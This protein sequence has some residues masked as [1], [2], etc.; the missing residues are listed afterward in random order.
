MAD[1]TRIDKVA[2]SRAGI[3]QRLDLGQILNGVQAERLKELLRGAVKLRAT[4]RI[5]TPRDPHKPLLHQLP[6]DFSA[7][8]AANLLHFRTHDRLLIRDHRERFERRGGQLQFV[9]RAF[10]ACEPRVVARSREKLIPA[11][12]FLDLKRAAIGV[13]QL[14]ESIQ[15]R[16]SFGRVGEIG[17]LR[18]TASGQ[19]FVGKQQQCFETG[20]LG[21]TSV[22]IEQELRPF[23]GETGT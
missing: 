8:H 13:V 4:Q 10:Q 18:E 15:Q 7:R 19:R 11:S 6:H 20:E 23:R 1:T 2:N 21:I 14:A 9:P 16:T 3:S 12:D 22:R 5:V 17:C